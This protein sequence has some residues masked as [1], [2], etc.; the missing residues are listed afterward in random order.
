MGKPLL[1]SDPEAIMWIRLVYFSVQ[2]V[3]VFLVFIFRIIRGTQLPR[4][5]GRNWLQP[6]CFKYDYYLQLTPTG[7]SKYYE[8]DG[9][10]IR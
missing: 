6:C 3:I 5:I 7:C 2:S 10:V 1:S 8:N 4:I 9:E